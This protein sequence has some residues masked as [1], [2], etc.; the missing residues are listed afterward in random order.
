[1]ARRAKRTKRPAP[2][3]PFA[4]LVRRRKAGAE[5]SP[6]AYRRKAKHRLKAVESEPVEG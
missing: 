6:R 3:N 2:R 5:K 1:M 4:I